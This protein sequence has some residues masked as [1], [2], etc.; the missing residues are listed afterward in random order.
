MVRQGA[1]CLNASL[2]CL[3]LQ[4]SA[5]VSEGGGSAIPKSEV[6]SA[7]LALAQTVSQWQTVRFNQQQRIRLQWLA[8]ETFMREWRSDKR[9]LPKSSK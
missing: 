1:L 2:L 7:L 6:K 5:A 9:R 4:S 3:P 8:S